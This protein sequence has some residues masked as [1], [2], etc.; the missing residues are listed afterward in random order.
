MPI[1]LKLWSMSRQNKSK[2]PS[3]RAPNRGRF[4]PQ[5]P[6]EQDKVEKDQVETPLRRVGDA[7][8]GV[9]G[10]F[11]RLRHD[12]AIEALDGIGAGASL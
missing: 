12:H 6:H 1:S 3:P 7:V 11:A 10:G 9:E 8:I 2:T 5:A 4:T